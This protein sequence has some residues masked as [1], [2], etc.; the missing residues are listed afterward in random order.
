MTLLASDRG[1]PHGHTAVLLRRVW[2][3]HDQVSADLARQFRSSVRRARTVAAVSAA[4]HLRHV[5]ADHAQLR[6]HHRHSAL[7]E[8]LGD[9]EARHGLAQPHLARSVYAAHLL[10]PFLVHLNGFCF[11]FISA[12]QFTYVVSANYHF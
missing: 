12:H 9:D 5:R 2:S 8:T 6:R 10:C 3:L 7:R 4:A 11:N 1:R